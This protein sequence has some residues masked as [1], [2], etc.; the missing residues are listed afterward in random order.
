MKSMNRKAQT[1]E[2]IA[3]TVSAFLGLILIVFAILYAVSALNPT[4]F[5]TAG[6]GNA[7]ATNALT[8]N[9]TTGV[10]GLGGYI[11]TVLSVLGIVLVIAAI[12]ILVLYVRRMQDHTGAG[13]GL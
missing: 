5:F 11:P 6:S 2:L 7:N 8:A 12:V 10:A 4:S 9:L 3:G 1:I 13:A